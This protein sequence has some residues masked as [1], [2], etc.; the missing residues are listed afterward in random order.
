LSWCCDGS[1]INVAEF[2]LR[3]SQRFYRLGRYGTLSWEGSTQAKSSWDYRELAI[4][5]KSY[6]ACRTTR[7]KILPGMRGV[8]C[9]AI[10]DWM[11]S[12]IQFVSWGSWW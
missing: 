4:R 6:R 9:C 1:D 11:F 7:D 3:L 12:Q 10:G 2:N 8:L 5:R